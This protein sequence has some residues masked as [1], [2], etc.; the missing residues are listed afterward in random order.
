[1]A[2]IAVTAVVVVIG[3]LVILILSEKDA[4]RGPK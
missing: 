4:K 3:A 2:T 1:M